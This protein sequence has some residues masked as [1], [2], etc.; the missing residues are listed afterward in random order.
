MDLQLNGRICLVTGASAGIGAG[1]ARVLAREGAQVALVARRKE[2]LEALAAEIAGAGGLAP[3]VVPGD[4]LDAAAPA[5]VA[6]T[7]LKSFGRVDVLVNNAGGS[8]PVPKD[9]A[10]VAW[11]EAMT[12]NFTAHR[13]MTQAVLDGMIE[14]KWGRIINITGGISGTGELSYVNAATTAKGAFAVW[15]KGLSNELAP[16]GIT[17]N[18]VAPGRIISEQILNRLLPTEDARAAYAKANI[19]VGYI[20]A[21]ED[22]ANLVAFIASPLARYITGSFMR[23]DGGMTRAAH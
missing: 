11:D 22:M 6:A 5:K 9:G 2:K 17:V 15:T 1:I 10:D 18:V 23:V 20:G 14:R 7:I 3:L 19:P 8:R 12:L 4:L 13:R 16:H 21:P